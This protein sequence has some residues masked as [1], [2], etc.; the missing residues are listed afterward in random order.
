MENIRLNNIRQI[1]K[2]VFFCFVLLVCSTG[3]A[4]VEKEKAEI[5]LG[6]FTVDAGNY[7]RINTPIRFQCSPPEIFCDFSI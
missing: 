3:Y 4:N 1:M 7:D 6:T 2:Y 5:V